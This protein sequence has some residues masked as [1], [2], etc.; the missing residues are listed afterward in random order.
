MILWEGTEVSGGEIPPFPGFY[1]KPCI[2]YCELELFPALLAD[3]A[4][5]RLSLIKA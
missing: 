2:E 1:M 3:Y 4:S 5:I